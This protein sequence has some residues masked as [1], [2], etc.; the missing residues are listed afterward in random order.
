MTFKAG[1]DFA[2]KL[3]SLGDGFDAIAK[4]AIYEG[5]KIATDEVRK[6]INALPDDS[7]RYLPNGEKFNG[8]PKGQKKDLLNGLG[9]TDMGYDGSGLLYTKIGFGG[10]GSY[11]TKKYTK[12]IPN[13]LLARSVES[14]SS[15]R[16]KTPFVRPAM[17]AVKQQV[18]SKMND[19]VSEKIKNIMK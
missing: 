9:L 14:G 2:V 18:V 8:I 10:Y 11:K 16:G 4:Q 12:G 5:A 6:R 3:A 13:Q 15:V 7:F 17:T 1:D 19:V